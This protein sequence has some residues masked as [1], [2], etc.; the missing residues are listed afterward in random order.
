MTRRPFAG[1]QLE[2]NPLLFQAKSQTNLFTNF[3]GKTPAQMRHQQPS[4]E[5]PSKAQMCS[6]ENAH[7]PTC[8]CGTLREQ[9]KPET[10]R[11]L[12]MNSQTHNLERMLNKAVLTA[13]N[14]S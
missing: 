12:Y 10:L 5:T 11:H 1:I 14:T 2:D 3:N 8:R 9:S 4:E 13:E 7:L 6:R